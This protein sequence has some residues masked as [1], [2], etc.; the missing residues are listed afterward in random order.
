MF[1]ATL[2]W[3]SSQNPVIHSQGPTLESL[4]R[5]GALAALRVTISDVLQADS[6]T[7]RGAFLVKGDA[8]LA[9]DLSKA[10]FPVEFKDAT[11]HRVRIILPPPRVLAAR[12][13]HERTLTWD[14]QHKIWVIGW[15]IAEGSIRDDAMRHGQRL[16]EHAASSP[17]YIE[18]ARSHAAEL[19]RNLYH[20]VGWEVE[21]LWS[22]HAKSNSAP[23]AATK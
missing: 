4:Q 20:E 16:I 13:D 7:H 23:A 3:S 11:N 18:L 19:I 21:V 12:L 8:T 17:E 6:S 10:S 1:G 9:V 5:L 14:V 2:L 22:D 15:L